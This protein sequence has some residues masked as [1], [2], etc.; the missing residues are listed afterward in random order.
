MKLEIGVGKPSGSSKASAVAKPFSVPRVGFPKMSPS[1]LWTEF[2]VPYE[3]VAFCPAFESSY[4][5]KANR[6]F[7]LF[8][9]HVD[10]EFESLQ[11]EVAFGFEEWALFGLSGNR[12]ADAR[13]CGFGEV[14]I[15]Y[16]RPAG[17]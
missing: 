8:C 11:V 6:L 14:T 13:T 10:L 16:W 4:H 5:K 3:P 2:W 9:L 1:W 12:L 17:A 7:W 15:L